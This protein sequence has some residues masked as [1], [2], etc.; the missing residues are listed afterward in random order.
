MSALLSL[1]LLVV[2]PQQPCHAYQAMR[3]ARIDGRVLAFDRHYQINGN[4]ALN[5][6]LLL[7]NLWPKPD[8][9]QFLDRSEVEHVD[10]W[11]MTYFQMQ[12]NDTVLRQLYAALPGPPS[13]IV[14]DWSTEVGFVLTGLPKLDKVFNVLGL[15]NKTTTAH[16]IGSGP[17]QEPLRREFDLFKFYAH[18][19]KVVERTAGARPAPCLR[20][21]VGEQTVLHSS[22]HEAT[23]GQVH[24]S[25]TS[26]ISGPSLSDFASCARLLCLAG[27]LR[28]HK[29]AFM[30]ELNAAGLLEPGVTAW[31]SGG[32]R[33]NPETEVAMLVKDNLP[34]LTLV[35]VG[36][37][38]PRLPHL[39][40]LDVNAKKPGVF[41]LM[42]DLYG[43]GRVSI[44]VETPHI[45]S[46]DLF[47]CG[48]VTLWYT[49]KTLKVMYLGAPFI[50]YA[51]PGM[52]LLMR[53]HGFRTFH[54][55]LNETY[56]TILNR[57]ARVNALVLEAKRIAGL[58]QAD[59]DELMEALQPVIQHNKEWLEGPTFASQLMHQLLYAMGVRDKPAFDPEEFRRDFLELENAV[60]F[61]CDLRFNEYYPGY[62]PFT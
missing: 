8:L 35:H 36:A 40:D 52:L 58:S 56:D 9:V 11:L 31:T 44:V 16:I 24:I 29:L 47:G 27:T 1:L 14:L 43:L 3:F 12:H 37:L 13:R 28:P 54:P 10:V 21:P 48:R 55:L 25:S 57:D 18:R 60:R 46:P 51:P 19:V 38:L 30:A 39:Y 42:P 4:T 59:F 50:A 41:D 34:A 49:E 62:R 53:S 2:G 23:A 15:T 5:A 20:H 7:P 45:N 33:Y 32:L 6:L 61:G 26:P 22:M 17:L